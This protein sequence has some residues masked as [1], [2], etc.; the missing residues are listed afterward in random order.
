MSENKEGFVW[1]QPG[2]DTPVE[3]DWKTGKFTGEPEKPE[4]STEHI[5]EILYGEALRLYNEKRSKQALTLIEISIENSPQRP[6]LHALE[7]V[8]YQ[9]LRRFGD[10]EKSFRKAL[11]LEPDSNEVLEN[12]ALMMY[13]WANSL[14]DKQKALEI[15][16]E[17]IEIL[18]QTELDSEKFWYMKGSVLDC[19]GRKTESR[20]CY[21]K[22]EKM[23]DEIS[24]LESQQE[25][26]LNSKDTLINIT[27]SQF[28]FGIEVFEKGMLVDLIKDTANEHDPDA[29]RVEIEGETVGFVANSEYTVIEG[30]KSASDIKKLNF[31]RAEI[32]FIYMDEYV[33]AK[34][35]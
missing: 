18:A 31:K 17:A 8:I 2:S 28:Y 15:I 5:A 14:N 12:Y 27:G 7:G 24:E 29:I 30:V 23:D 11:K 32:M 4:N 21:L 35:V 26:L 10:S 16:T 34:L 6:E 20:I 9:D 1:R 3:W 33:I 13:D 19:L 25:M 22:A